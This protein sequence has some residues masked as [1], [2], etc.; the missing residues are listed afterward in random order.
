MSEKELTLDKA[1]MRLAYDLFY[2]RYD[3]NL[4]I[5]WKHK[6]NKPLFHESIDDYVEEEILMEWYIEKFLTDPKFRSTCED[7]IVD[8]EKLDDEWVLREA[9]EDYIP[10]ELLD[11]NGAIKES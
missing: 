8:V 3:C 6:Y 10:L 9:M 5:W 11:K 1:L 4:E 2:N 7:D